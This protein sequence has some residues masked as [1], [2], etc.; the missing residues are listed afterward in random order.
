VEVG[1]NGCVCLRISQQYKDGSAESR[2]YNMVEGDGLVVYE[3]PTPNTGEV[4]A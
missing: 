1:D 4:D 2:D 3:R